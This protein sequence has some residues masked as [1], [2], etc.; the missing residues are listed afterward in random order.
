[1]QL[2]A[3]LLAQG[4]I[5]DTQPGLGRQARHADLALVHGVV[6]LVRRLT[7]LLQR[8]HLAEHRMD[9]ALADQPVCLPASW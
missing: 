5:G 7:C 3:D 1:V 9:L 8:E 2:V 6:H 4:V